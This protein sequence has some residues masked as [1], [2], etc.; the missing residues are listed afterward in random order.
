[1]NP[2]YVR[3]LL[4]IS[5]KTGADTQSKNIFSHTNWEKASILSQDFFPAAYSGIIV[6]WII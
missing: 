1:M 6:A 3:G 2:I 4:A 5:E